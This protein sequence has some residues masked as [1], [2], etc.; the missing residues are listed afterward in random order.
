MAASTTIRH[1]LILGLAALAASPFA[2]AADSPPAATLPH[3]APEPPPRIVED[4][5]RV[6]LTLLAAGFDTDLRLDQSPGVPGTLINAENDLGLATSD[7]LPMAEITLLPG[8]RHLLRLSGLGS[9]RTARKTLERTISFG[10]Q[11]YLAG[12]RVD[13]ELD[14]TMLGLVYGYRFIARDNAEFAATLGVQILEVEANA[15]VRSRVLRD[16]ESGVIPLALLGLEG[17]F[18]L[19]AR[20]SFE[21]RVQY[22]SANIDAVDGSLL[23][24]RLALTWRMNPYL[25]F[26][27]G[28]RH[29]TIEVD[30]RDESTAGL[31]DLRLNG[32]ALFVRASL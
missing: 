24:A 17:R 2:L 12:E 18:E 26:G 3:W 5:V 30:S 8:E 31:A 16:A 32:P 28:Y 27:A 29:F 15:L 9:R 22:L 4:R 7:L 23:D 13:S 11:T 1:R 20:W 6:E 21:G 14:L 19:D 25:V 10:D